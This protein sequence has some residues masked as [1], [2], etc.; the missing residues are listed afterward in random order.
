[1]KVSTTRAEGFVMARQ[2]GGRACSW[3]SL[4]GAWHFPAADAPQNAPLASDERPV[5][6]SRAPLLL[7]IRRVYGAHRRS[8]LIAYGLHEFA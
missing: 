1:M 5:Y 8:P 2:I 4:D 7:P 3:L 6:S